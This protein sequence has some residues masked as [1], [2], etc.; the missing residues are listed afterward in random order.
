MGRMLTGFW[1]RGPKGRDH[2][3]DLEVGGRIILKGPYR[4]RDRMDELD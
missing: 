4:D 1:L 3:E 2:W